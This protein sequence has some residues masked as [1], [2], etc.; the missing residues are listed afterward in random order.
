MSIGW[1]VG[2]VFRILVEKPEGKR[3]LVNLDTGGRII[4]KWI[5]GL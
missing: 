3:Y 1:M 2:N 5:S 4:L